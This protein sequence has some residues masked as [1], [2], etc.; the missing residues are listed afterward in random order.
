MELHCKQNESDE[1]PVTI[2][3]YNEQNKYVGWAKYTLANNKI[4]LEDLF[5]FK[6]FRGNKLSKSMFQTIFSLAREKRTAVIEADIRPRESASCLIAEDDFNYF[7]KL[8]RLINI[9]EANGFVV[10]PGEY[11][12]KGVCRLSQS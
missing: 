8:K 1:Y 12:A 11:D 4:I 7:K 5:I 2:D 6:D 9:F 10:S 3:F